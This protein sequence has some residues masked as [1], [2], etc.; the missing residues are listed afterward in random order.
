LK[1]I[2]LGDSF[3]NSYGLE[4]EIAIQNKYIKH[5]DNL[6][7]ENK[8]DFYLRFS[9]DIKENIQNIKLNNS[10]VKKLSDELKFEY[11]NIS[12]FGIGMQGF[13]N[14]FLDF[15]KNNKDDIL[16]LLFLPIT[17]FNRILLSNL[18]FKYKINDHVSI[19]DLYETY[20]YKYNDEKTKILK[21][22]FNKEYFYFLHL[23]I[24]FS[25]IY[26]LKNKNI[27]F[28][29]LPTWRKNIYDHF[30]NDNLNYNFF[31]KENFIEF[32]NNKKENSLF[33]EYYDI[34]IFNEIEDQMN[35]NIDI[36]KIEKLPCGHPNLNSQTIIV[37]MYYDYIKKYIDSL[38]NINKI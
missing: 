28:L 27:P 32:F 31:I 17:N 6:F 1:L 4:V 33:K 26:Y 14:I 22:K 9:N 5:N 8:N 11:L 37:N 7:F 36:N 20:L 29:F 25:L 3:T 30:F 23:N 38:Y 18:N 13:Y 12:Q 35:F 15:E 16:Y 34:F 2:F 21:K 19:Y 24:L 10:W